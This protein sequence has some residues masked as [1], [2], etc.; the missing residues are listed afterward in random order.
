MNVHKTYFKTKPNLPLYCYA[1]CL[2]NEW[3]DIDTDIVE[4]LNITDEKQ[5]KMLEQNHIDNI[6]LANLYN[7]NNAYTSVEYK[8]NYHKSY[9]NKWNIDNKEHVQQI[10]KAY[11]QKNKE[12]IKAKRKIYKMKNKERIKKVDEQ[13]YLRNKTKTQQRHSNWALNNA[14]RYC[15]TACNFRTHIKT[16]YQRHLNTKRHKK[17]INNQ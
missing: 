5:I 3:D 1:R 9:S 15:C 16:C 13:Y 12:K 6:G 7:V 11:R 17:V 10:G 8:K 14:D 2:F 4:Y